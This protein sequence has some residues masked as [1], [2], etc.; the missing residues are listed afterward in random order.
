M[1]SDV[2]R[3]RGESRASGACCSATCIHGL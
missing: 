3:S 1:T 2:H